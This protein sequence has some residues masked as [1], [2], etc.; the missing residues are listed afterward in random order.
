MTNS[1]YNPTGVPSTNADGL[2]ADMR[3]E[4]DLIRQGFE[5]FPDPAGHPSEP[6]FANAAANG[7]ELKNAATARTALGVQPT[8]DPTF[9]GT[10]TIPT[11]TKNTVSGVAASTEFASKLG[12]HFY[13][14]ILGISTNTTLDA[15]DGGLPFEVQANVIVDLPD[16][17]NTFYSITTYTFKALSAFTLRAAGGQSINSGLA[18]A[19]TLSVLQGETITIASNGPGSGSWY[20]MANGF[21]AASM[22]LKANLAS[23]SFS[24]SPTAPTKTRLTNDTT[25]AT[26]AALLAHGLQFP[27]AGIGISGNTTLTVANSGKWYEVQGV[28]LTVTLP[29]LAGTIDGVAYCLIAAQDFTLKGSG[30]ETIS[31]GVGAANSWV[32]NKGQRLVVVANSTAWYI[33]IDGFT[34][35][36]FKNSISAGS[37]YIKHPGGIMEVI[38]KYITP[39]SAWTGQ[40]VVFPQAFASIV[41]NIQLTVRSGGATNIDV[42]F[43]GE[44][45]NGFDSYCSDASVIVHYRALGDW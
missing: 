25:L 31:T 28:G 18:S 5:K 17:T 15:D 37:G 33:P 41:H 14:N 44:T 8:N 43:S 9:T 27:G 13:G 6:V 29:A 30:A 36:H 12:M 11:A 45:I 3:N 4:F 26:M 24:G 10:V 7:F 19:N 34:G 38:G 35:A 21:G 1:Y 16:T 42:H 2:S 40:S 22:N 20:V 32:V 23:P 39:G